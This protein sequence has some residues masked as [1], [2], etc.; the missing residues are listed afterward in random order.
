MR[1]W[2]HLIVDLDRSILPRSS[3]FRPVCS[4][5]LTC[6]NPY[7][8][9]FKPLLPSVP[10]VISSS[11][12]LFSS[13]G[14]SFLIVIKTY[15]CIGFSVANLRCDSHLPIPLRYLLHFLAKISPARSSQIL[16][17]KVVKFLAPFLL[18]RPRCHCA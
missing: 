17:K 14:E 10:P 9:F 6:S 5:F 16:A 1:R 12:C 13:F 3:F 8:P 11:T 4:P 15:C 2:C 18:L 7:R